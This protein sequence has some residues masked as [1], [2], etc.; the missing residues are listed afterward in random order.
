MSKLPEDLLKLAR[1]QAKHEDS[2]GYFGFLDGYFGFL[3]GV[4]WLWTYLSEQ[5]LEFDATAA[6]DEFEKRWENVD[7]ANDAY[8]GARWQFERDK[9]RIA[10]LLI[11]NEAS[12]KLVADDWHLWR[13]KYYDKINELNAAEAKLA[14]CEA[15]LRDLMT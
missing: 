9:E 15:K 13:E 3:T 1:D 2:D 4:E 5:S 10:Q 8:E 12:T 11:T 6:C 14:E 7:R